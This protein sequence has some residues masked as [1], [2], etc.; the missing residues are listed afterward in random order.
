MIFKHLGESIDIHGG[1]L[2]L[3]FPHHENEIA[4]AEGCTHKP[5]VK[6]WVHNNMFTFDGAKMSKSLGNIRTMRSFLQE[7]P[8]EVF[9]FLTLSSHYRSQTEFSQKTLLH[10][11]TGLCRIYESIKNAHAL[12]NSKKAPQEGPTAEA[13]KTS[14]QKIENEI[15]QSFNDDFNTAKAMGSLFEL[16]RLY[17]STCPVNSKLTPEKVTVAKAFTSFI[18]RTGKLLSLFQENPENFLKQM[19]QILAD[20]L[21]LKTH[22]IE[23]FIQQRTQFKK[24]KNFAKADQIRE[25]LNKKGVLIKDTAQGSFWEIDKSMFLKLYEELQESNA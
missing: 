20:K 11:I 17:N 25:D 4:Q 16:V 19:D 15:T 9:K 23:D 14:L 24:D 10:S 6:Y 8:G 7:Y 21:Q 3:V 22:E 5:Y 1:G 2:D 18:E 13:F 12:L